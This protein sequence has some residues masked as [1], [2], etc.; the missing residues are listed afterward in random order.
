MLEQLNRI[1]AKI[2]EMIVSTTENRVNIDNHTK[3]DGKIHAG[4]LV[5]AGFVLSVHAVEAVAFIKEM[6]Q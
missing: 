4:L 2:D 5:L 6:V 1:E 3:Y